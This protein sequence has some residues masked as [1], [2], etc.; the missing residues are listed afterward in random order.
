MCVFSFNYLFVCGCFIRAIASLPGFKV[1]PL[2]QF[3]S[4]GP[5]ITDE[6]DPQKDTYVLVY[7]S[8]ATNVLYLSV[9]LLLTY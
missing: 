8:Y 1:L 3:G 5:G 4:W 7:F 2:R 9:Y 6:L